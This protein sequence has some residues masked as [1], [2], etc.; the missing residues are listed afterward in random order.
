[1]NDLNKEKLSYFEGNVLDY[2]EDQLSS[3]AK[4][5]ETTARLHPENTVTIV[6]EQ[7]NRQITYCEL[8]AQAKVIAKGLYD[9]EVQAGDHVLFQFHDNYDFIEV[10]WGCFVA[11]VRVVPLA[12]PP[13]YEH[14]SANLLKLQNTLKMLGYPVIVT[15]KNIGREIEVLERKEGWE[16]IQTLEVELLRK[17]QP[18]TE[19]N[20][21]NPDDTAMLLLTSGSA[22]L[23][24]AVVL[25]HRNILS[26]NAATTQHDKFDNNDVSLNWMPLDHVG[27]VVMFHIRDVFS[28]ANQVQV[29]TQMIL[30][31][32]LLWLDLIERFQATATWAP[33]FA[34]GLV[35][36][37]LASAGVRKWNLSSLRY[38]LNGG[39]AVVSKTAR[40]FLKKLSAHGLSGTIMKPSWGMSE[41]SSGVASS[42]DFLLENTS[43][44][45]L[46]V[47]VGMALPGVKLRIVDPKGDIVNEGDIG[48]LQIT[49]PSVTSG[50]YNN[51]KE[52]AKA[53]TDDGWFIT[54]D[55][56]I[57]Q[58]G[59]LS[60]TGRLKEVII[61][62]GVNFYGHEIESNVDEIDEVELSY[63]AVCPVRMEST[64]TDEV[65]IFFNTEESHDEVIFD[66]IK[67]IRQT[68]LDK[69]GFSPQYIIPIAKSRIPKT[70]IGKIQR[71]KLRQQLEEGV[72]SDEIAKWS[73]QSKVSSIPSWTFKKVIRPITIDHQPGF[74]MPNTLLIGNSGEPFSCL[75]RGLLRKNKDN[76]SSIIDL[77]RDYIRYFEQ[78][79]KS[80]EYVNIIWILPELPRF[81][82]TALAEYQQMFSRTMSFVLKVFQDICTV[83]QEGKSIHLLAVTMASDAS[84]KN[85]KQCEVG[86]GALFGLLRS[87]AKELV[88][89][90]CHVVRWLDSNEALPTI[91]NMDFNRAS[92]ITEF[93]VCDS[94]LN[95][96][97]LE[98]HRAT[99]KKST[100]CQE[101]GL[102]VVTGGLGGVGL[103]LCRFLRKRY[104]AKL[105]L[106]GR[107]QLESEADIRQKAGLF[108][109]LFEDDVF[110][111]YYAVDLADSNLLS[112]IIEA[113]EEKSKTPLAGVF[114]LA[115]TYHEQVIID[116]DADSL[117]TIMSPKAYGGYSL[118]KL[119]HD[120]PDVLTVFFSSVV[121]LEGGLSVGGYTAANAFLEDLSSYL[122]MKGHKRV[123]SFGWSSWADTGMSRGFVAKEALLAKGFME[124]DVD[125]ALESMLRC[126]D[127][128]KAG[129]Y[130]VGL[131]GANVHIAPYLNVDE[132]EEYQI[133]ANRPSQNEKVLSRNETEAKLVT[134]WQRLLKKKNIGVNDNFF[135]LG[136]SSIL[137]AVLVAEVGEVFGEKL[138]IVT[139][140]TA[141]TIEK[142]AQLIDSNDYQAE[143][144]ISTIV[145]IQAGSPEVKKPFFCIPGGG[146]D[147]IAFKGLSEAIGEEIPFYGLQGK[148]L[149]AVEAE[150]FISIE[151]M[152]KSF[153]E[154]MKT[155]QNSGPYRIGGH[156]FGALLAYEM[157]IQLEKAGEEVG[158]VALLDPIIGEELSSNFLGGGRLSYHWQRFC[159]IPF[160]RKLAYIW[161]KIHNFKRTV[162]M[163]RR[164]KHSLNQASEM[165]SKYTFKRYGGFV[166]I[167]LADDSYCKT[168]G[169]LDPRK[170]WN[171]Y[172]AIPPSYYVVMGDHDTMLR[173]SGKAD[174]ATQLRPFL[175]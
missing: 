38:A 74:D 101:G 8:W 120:R 78:S 86:S 53:F 49:G 6:N 91:L 50:Y 97:A 95:E 14:P 107:E 93:T 22:G 167:F 2:Q 148:G 1:M 45:D 19:A 159:D 129:V 17:A 103:Q 126:L 58:N 52:N 122:L 124:L 41:T 90:K 145:K 57:L 174:L 175:K 104:N 48:S 132:R 155:I 68:V 105:I 33:N 47:S 4:T 157:A 161:K 30:K 72:F 66:I 7:G 65:A 42:N 44:D 115:G 98:G 37:N 149:D 51:E 96:Q 79:L 164:V 163:R 154:D 99:K 54:G 80:R 64:D 11:G 146:S 108:S 36:E 130:Y 165:L 46:F 152:A 62:N 138:P 123:F 60:I 147:S 13:D 81:D 59:C 160:Q 170:I 168:Q 143:R 70:E 28:G 121:T 39:E 92:D 35:N 117:Q 169:E 125:M 106:F 127:S 144:K 26:R 73:G 32:P 75:S 27:G 76:N 150:R 10:L 55:L 119:L 12:M 61:I 25:S 142:L 140:F 118:V 111:K 23:P 20:C 69:H 67:R 156:C 173:S 3:L 15:S 158:F 114:H 29:E 16:T 34:F 171:K 40:T 109:D 100:A 31:Q 153:I 113:A 87:A 84:E 112:E 63:T 166:N 151:E 18:I 56:A 77:D 89:L 94:H 131:D 135:E 133:T 110:T 141:S 139:L 128:E 71:S 134:I 116:E 136:G 83:N 24:K 162:I 85:T 137:A 88:W 82:D 21:N 172:T 43:D 5:L 102:Y 9:N